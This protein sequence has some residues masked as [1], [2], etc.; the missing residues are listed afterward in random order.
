MIPMREWE[1]E[2]GKSITGNDKKRLLYALDISDY[3]LL[4]RFMADDEDISSSVSYAFCGKIAA[5]IPT[6]ASVERLFSITGHLNDKKNMSIP[7]N[8]SVD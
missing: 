1:K 4:Q 8:D 3:T 2:T 6:E 5:Q 7:P